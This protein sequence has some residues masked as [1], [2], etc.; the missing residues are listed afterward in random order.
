MSVKAVRVGL[1]RSESQKTVNIRCVKAA[2]LSL[3]NAMNTALVLSAIRNFHIV[4]NVLGF[5]PRAILLRTYSRLAFIIIICV[6][7]V[8]KLKLAG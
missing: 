8:L 7:D 5:A 4:D 3:M 6:Q 2:N 1:K